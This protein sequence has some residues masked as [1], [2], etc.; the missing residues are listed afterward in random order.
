VTAPDAANLQQN[1]AGAAGTPDLTV[2]RGGG[3][4]AGVAGDGMPASA[5]VA[6]DKLDLLL[7]IDNS[8][9]MSDKQEVLGAALPDLMN[10]LV[11]PICL[12][13]T[14]NEFPAPAPGADCPLGQH[15]QFEPIADIHIGIVSSSLGDI[16]ANAACPSPGLPQFVADRVD[17]GHLIGSLP[18]GQVSGTNAR[19]FLEWHAG[20]D[21]GLFNGS[22]QRM[23]AS[24]GENGC[25]WEASLEAW[26]RFLIDTRPY[27][28][29]ARVP[30][31]AALA[32]TDCVAPALDADGQ[33]LLDQEL[34]AQRA[35]FLRPDSLVAI[36]MLTDEN[37]CSL[38]P[39]GTNWLV[40][41]IGRVE[42]MFRG[43]SACDVDPN[44]KCCRSCAAAAPAGCSADPVCDA[45]VNAGTPANR[46]PAAADG[47]GLRCFDQKRRFGYDFRY[48]TQRYVRALSERQ[49][50]LEQ[51]DLSTLD[52]PGPLQPNPLFA[53]GRTPD[54]VLLAGIV[55]V[56]WQ[57]ISSGT[58][59][60]GQPLSSPDRQLRFKSSR[61]LSD[62]DWN[63][64]AGSPGTPWRAATGATPEIASSPPLPPSEPTM[65]E[66]STSRPS[67]KPGNPINGRDYDTAL[68]ARANGTPN[69]LEYAC[70]FPLPTPRDCSQQDISALATCDCDADNFNRPLCEATPGNGTPGTTQYWAKAYPGLRQLQVLRDL[71]SRSVVASICARNTTDPGRPDFGYRPAV[72]AIIEGLQPQLDAR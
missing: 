30:C 61:E 36:V 46:L 57:A 37:D 53:G 31:E 63:R 67:V 8:I 20:A 55:G 62:A 22:F 16:G 41:D 45:D 15:R 11:N 64:I 4:G 44:S 35:E 40:V 1:G 54:Q 9:S 50:C 42:T 29:L 5:R 24:V 56:P 47:A 69:D 52:C 43:T 28:G 49:L 14:G 58:A 21:L 32:S 34:L 60:N 38:E 6:P 66:S 2:G 68:G 71:G 17:M 65:L 59:S 3:G 7:M 12:D 72:T 18:R 70:I 13:A 19:G 25:G 51:P 33:P 23:L 48:P 10:R 27:Q 39:A 26:Y